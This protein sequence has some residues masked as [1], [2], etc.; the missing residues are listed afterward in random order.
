M[1]VNQNRILQF[2]TGA[3]MT[4]AVAAGAQ[5]PA[6][7]APASDPAPAAPAQAPAPA[8]APAAAPTWSVGPM[9]ISGLIDGYYSYNYNRP[10]SLANGQM[11]DFYNF[12]DK[13]DQF[14]LARHVLTLNH[15]PDPVGAHVDL[16]FRPREY[17]GQRP[18]H[19]PPGMRLNFSNRPS[20]VSNLRKPRA[21]S[22]T[23][24]N[25]SPLRE[26]K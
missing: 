10:G 6:P 12:N 15:D 18:F 14:N 7:P 4:I 26:R 21:W 9:D 20:L 1:H 5:A 23:S 22:W 16:I 13:T 25:S 17:L 8:A 24:A 2:L 11:N 3:A 19:A